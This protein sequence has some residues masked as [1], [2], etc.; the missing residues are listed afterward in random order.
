MAEVDVDDAISALLRREFGFF[1]RMAFD[2]LGG[3]DAYIHNWHIDALIH[4]LDRVRSGD[5]RRLI[6]T[7]PPRHL[8]SRVISIAW[9]AWMLGHNPA[10]KF[11]CV[12][13]GQSL[14]EDHAGDCLRIMR[15]RWYA[16][17]FPNMVL[18]SRAIA[19]LK[20]SAGGGRISSSVEGPITGFGADII[21]V[22]DP[23]KAQD[24][25]SPTARD[26]A[27]RWFDG[28][29]AQRLNSQMTGSIIVTMQRLHE[30]D[31]VGTLRKQGGFY[32]LCLP[33]IAPADEIIPLTRG[34]FYRRRAGFALHPARQS[35]VMLE[36]RKA[37][38]PYV[39]AGQF[40]QDPIPEIGNIIEAAWI[41]TYDLAGIDLSQGQIVM[42]LDT[43]SKDN[44]FNDFSAIVIARVLGKSIHIIDV[45]RAR[46]KIPELKA[47][48]IELARLHN[49]HVML[50]EDA[51][52]GHQL[53]QLL[54]AENPAGVPSPIAR[55]P[56]G[57]KTSRVLGASAL[58]QAGR[59]FVPERAHWVAEYTGELLGFPGAA[60]DDQVDATSQL[61]LWVLEKDMYRLPVNDGPI[62]MDD[63][64][65]DRPSSVRW[66]LDERDPWGAY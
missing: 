34:R 59:L 42:S 63:Y 40:Q 55:R 19:Y 35:L 38:S 1:L 10:L 25:L 50:I 27:N 44:P 66:D 24:A 52:S 14:A 13:Y 57:D 8:K 47:K 36:A 30:A 21:I 54:E 23:L 15:S 6:V 41:L 26:T 4:Q 62:L 32:E 28:T 65:G 58:I 43:A 3:N 2:E 53:V 33:A 16:R 7:M 17:A 20:T 61:L 18:T 5:N 46:L 48:T 22:D 11:Q 29:L 45:F 39:F 49:A 31:L 12:S 56:K 60:F 51:V 37:A 64:D 9:V